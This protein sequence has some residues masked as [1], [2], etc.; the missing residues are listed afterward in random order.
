MGKTIDSFRGK[1]YF[2]SNFYNQDVIYQGL[3]FLNNEAAFQAMKV[4]SN[5]EREEFTNAPPNIAKRLGRKVKLRK[6]WEEVKDNYMYEIVKAKF[7]QS[8]KLR[9][10]LLKTEDSILIEGNT[11]CDNEWGN[12]SCHKC[13]NYQGKNKLGKIL[14]KVRS[15]LKSNIS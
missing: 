7:Y 11:W 4:L 5:K 3:K 8:E 1:Y 15:E 6:D 12:C 13:I 14:M 10:E 9:N 2:L